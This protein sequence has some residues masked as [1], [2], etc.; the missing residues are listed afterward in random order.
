VAAL[1]GLDLDTYTP[2]QMTYDLRRLRLKGLIE[3]LPGSHRYRLTPLGLRAAYFYTKL[4]LRILR[5]A[6]A[7][8][9]PQHDPIPRP[10]RLAFEHLDAEIARL[11]DQARLRP[12]A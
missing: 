5:P 2:G 7:A 10:L 9:A 8:M 6:W 4:H 11:F 1:L 12:A 3:R